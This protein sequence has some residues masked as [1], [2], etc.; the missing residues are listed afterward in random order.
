M[1]LG[2]GPDKSNLQYLLIMGD[3]GHISDKAKFTFST[4]N[5]DLV[6]VHVDNFAA[7]TVSESELRYLY[8]DEDY[9]FEEEIDWV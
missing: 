6:Y 8:D 3:G 4:S 5:D 2:T 9:E 1:P 7:Y